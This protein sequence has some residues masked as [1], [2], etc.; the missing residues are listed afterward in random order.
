MLLEI[1]DLRV[2][3]GKMEALKRMTL[4]VKQGEIVCL[5][6]PNGAGKTTTL[7]T[8]CGLIKPVAGSIKFLS[9]PIHG[10]R[11]SSIP[12]KGIALVPQGRRLFDDQT[13]MDNLMLGAYCRRQ[14][15]SFA[16][17]LENIFKL[18]PVLSERRNQVANTLSG[19]EQQMLTIGRAIMSNPSLL[20]LDKPSIGLAP[21]LVEEVFRTIV[22]LNHGGIAILLAE[23]MAWSALEIAHRAYVLTEGRVVLSGESTELME[24]ER[25]VQAY[26]PVEGTEESS[27]THQG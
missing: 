14:G 25:V 17:N 13:V 5:I 26:F 16:A 22:R 12:R 21:L 4:E 1:K 19:G 15:G 9:E 6:G 7:N 20:L 8:I 23:Q 11:A 24:N 2:Y 10:L 3:Y 18:F 27:T